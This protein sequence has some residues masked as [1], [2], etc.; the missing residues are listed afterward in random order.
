MHTK[1]AYAH[2][3]GL[4]QHQ[5]HSQGLRSITPQAHSILQKV[6]KGKTI[7]PFLKTFSWRLFRSAL[8]TIESGIL[9]I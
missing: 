8:A 5:L 3:A 2:L 7:H 4:F 1:E 6:Y 9:P